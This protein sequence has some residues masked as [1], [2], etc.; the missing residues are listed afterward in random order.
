MQILQTT[1]SVIE[2]YWAFVKGILLKSNESAKRDE[3]FKQKWI[4]ALKKVTESKIQAMMVPTL[5]KVQFLSKR[6]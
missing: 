4:A 3:E 6:P 5:K 2:S 1:Q